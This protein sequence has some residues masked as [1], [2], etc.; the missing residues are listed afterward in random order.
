VGGRGLWGGQGG[1]GKGDSVKEQKG[2]QSHYK[3][4]WGICI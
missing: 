2:K 4:M 3:G 1:C